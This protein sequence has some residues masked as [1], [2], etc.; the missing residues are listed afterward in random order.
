MPLSCTLI[1]LGSNVGDRLA[2]LRAGVDSLTGLGEILATSS[3]YETAPVG[4]ED[5]PPF[6]NA[7]VQLAT[8]LAPQK[9]LH[10]LLRIEREHGR[11]RSSRNVPS[12]GPRTLDLDLLLYSD[13]I[14]S[15]DDLTIPH[16]ELQQRRF[17][18]APLAEIAG[19]LVHPVLQN[20]MQQLLAALP[21]T[22]ANGKDAVRRFGPLLTRVSALSSA[23]ADLQ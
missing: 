6:F 4:F 17:V 20:T 18:L 21:D 11:D 10:E 16:P 19:D 12:Q 8:A 2:H 22:G 9:L 14:L 15:T 13:L 5:Q 1:G 3:V 7:V 23:R